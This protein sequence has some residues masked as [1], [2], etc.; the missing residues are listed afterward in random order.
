MRFEN[1]HDPGW[2]KSG[3]SNGSGGN[4][5]V[6]VKY[7]EDGVEVRNSKNPRKV[8]PFTA[9]EFTAFVDGV[10]DGDFDR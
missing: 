5:C 8:L 9:A 6:E 4:N 7:V 2:I 3:V 10:R 1:P